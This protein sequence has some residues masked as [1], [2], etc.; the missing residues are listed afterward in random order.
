MDS[1]NS[2]VSFP[3]NAKITRPGSVRHPVDPGG[4][5]LSLIGDDLLSEIAGELNIADVGL[6]REVVSDMAGGSVSKAG[7][8]NA[9][10]SVLTEYKPSDF[11]QV[12]IKSVS[13]Q[14]HYHISEPVLAERERESITLVKNVF[15]RFIG[16]SDAVLASDQYARREYLWNKFQDIIKLYNLKLTGEERQRIFYYIERDFLKYG[17]L[18]AIMNDRYIEDV[19]CNGP[20]QPLYVYHREYGSVKTNVQFEE[21]ELNEFILRL[22]QLCGKHISILNPIMDASLPEGSRI[23]MTLGSEVTK[24][25]SSFTIR[26]FKKVPISPVELML[27]GSIDSSMLAYMWMMV[28]YNRSF[29]VSGGTAS[30]KTTLLNAICMFVKPQ[31]KIISI[32]D[33]PE[34]NLEH[35]LASSRL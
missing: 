20:G 32:E 16:V 17:K 12:S 7:T 5:D 9:G 22:S 2:G 18:D 19:S 11:Q 35:K 34:I 15:D 23:N 6:L 27:Y 33:T 8:Q 25:G 28:D 14:L 29:L 21:K 13:G 3:G 31:Y 24:K 10:F 1:T 26:K 30:G 4:L